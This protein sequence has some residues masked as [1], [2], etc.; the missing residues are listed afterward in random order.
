MT[1]DDL[2]TP[3]SPT[4]RR[5]AIYPGSFDP[6]HNG[7]VDIAR[8]AAHLFD[9]LV[10]AVYD[11]PSKSLLFTPEER[12]ELARA[13]FEGPNA[14]VDG[15]KISVEGFSGLLVHYAKARGAR[16]IVRGLR[17]V[18]DFEAESQMTLMNRYLESEVETV[19]LMTSLRYAYLSSS[20]LKEVVAGGADMRDQVPP[21]VAAAL[22]ERYAR[23]RP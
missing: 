15:C 7:H 19:F 10:I 18:T 5:I 23:P 12:F 1:E 22:A 13:S 14:R 17:A 4:A 6:I 16:A 20:L 3:S 8:R 21:A 11:R 2:S 9:E